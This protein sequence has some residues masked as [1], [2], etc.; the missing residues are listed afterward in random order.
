MFSFCTFLNANS[1]SLF[2]FLKVVFSEIR[3]TVLVFES[4]ARAPWNDI[5]N[6]QHMRNTLTFYAKSFRSNL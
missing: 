3:A 4:C 2:S 5:Y 6:L 1:M